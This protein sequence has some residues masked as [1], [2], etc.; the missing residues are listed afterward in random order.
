VQIPRLREWRERRA[1][2]QVELAER[3]GVSARSVAGYEAGGG[4]RLPTVRRLA[5]ALGIEVTDLYGEAGHPLGQA[6]PSQERLF[7]GGTAERRIIGID[8]GACQRA[9][10]GLCDRW[11]PVL[12]EAV[13]Q[14]HLDP[15]TFREFESLVGGLTPFIDAVVQV[16]MTERGQEF[17]D[18]GVLVFWS[19]RSELWPA[20]GQFQDI[21]LHLN[22][23]AKK[24][25]GEESAVVYELAAYRRHAA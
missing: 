10:E 7:N 12:Q 1:I 19:E 25:F 14:D 13:S 22:R 21:A 6:S 8:Y 2:T 16:E 5:H 15:E 20:L 23:L 4:A 17:D 24:H 9:L 3:A 11:Q 18:E